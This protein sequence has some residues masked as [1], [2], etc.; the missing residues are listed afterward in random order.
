MRVLQG[1]V[2]VMIGPSPFL[3]WWCDRVL[4]R[5]ASGCG[6]TVKNLDGAVH[7]ACASGRE[8][9]HGSLWSYASLS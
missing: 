5:C 9:P 7:I 2:P 1:M 4:Q 8:D 6:G 3:S